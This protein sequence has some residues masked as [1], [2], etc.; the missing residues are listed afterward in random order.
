MGLLTREDIMN[1]VVKDNQIPIDFVDDGNRYVIYADM[2]GVAKEDIEIEIKGKVLMINAKRE[3][4]V[5]SGF[6]S[7]EIKTGNLC[8]VIELKSD[9]E[10]TKAVAEYNYGLLKI[11]IPKEQEHEAIKVKIS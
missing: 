4:G 6:H 7:S 11:I 10:P 5:K 1:N 2:C 8:K 3:F 9:I